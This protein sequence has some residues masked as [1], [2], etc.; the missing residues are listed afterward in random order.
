MIKIHIFFK[1]MLIILR[2]LWGLQ[3]ILRCFLFQLIVDKFCHKSRHT[4]QS[5]IIMQFTAI[6]KKSCCTMSRGKYLVCLVF[7]CLPHK[8]RKMIALLNPVVYKTARDI[9]IKTCFFVLQF[10]VL[11]CGMIVSLISIF[12]QY[13]KYGYL[14]GY[15]K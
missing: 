9:V 5:K 10:F 6:Y 4:S 7:S 2:R 11:V 1:T 8:T 15:R 13:S 3:K 14:N 12:K